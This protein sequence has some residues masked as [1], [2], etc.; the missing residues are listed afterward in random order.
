MVNPGSGGRVLFLFFK[1]L[2]D[3]DKSDNLAI[4]E[5]KGRA[6]PGSGPRWAGR[7]NWCTEWLTAR[8]FLFLFGLCSEVP[9]GDFCSDPSSR[10]LGPRYLRVEKGKGCVFL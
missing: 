2:S 10:I 6:S 9:S 3:S 7:C 1:E 4:E 5:Q 8:P